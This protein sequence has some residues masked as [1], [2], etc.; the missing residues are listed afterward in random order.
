MAGTVVAGESNTVTWT[1]AIS[2]QECIE[3][4]LA[5]NLEIQVERINPRIA[6]WGVVREQGGFEPTLNGRINYQDNHT[7]LDPETARSLGFTNIVDQQLKFGAD[8][9]GKLPTGASYDLSALDTRYGGTLQPSN[10]LHIAS[11]VLTLDQPL[12]RNF[13]FG[14][15][16]ASIRVARKNRQIV[17]EQFRQRVI[18][19]VTAVIDAYYDLVR[20]I[21]DHKAQVEDLD[22]AQTLL[23]Q[24]RK[25]VDAGILPPIEVTQAEAGVAER[26]EGVIVTEQAIRDQENTVK[27]LISRDAL[28]LVDASLVPV[29]H[30][31]TEITAVDAKQSIRMA[32]ENRPDFLQAKHEL[33]RRGILLK[34]MRNQL[35]P[36]IDVQGSYGLNGRA[37][38]GFGDTA[39]NLSAGDNPQWS[40]GV[41]V[42]IPLG[43][44][45]ARADYFSARE[46]E[47]RA[48]L[49]LKRLEQ[50]IVV[51]VGNLTGQVR[52]N[53]KRMDATR[54]ARRLAEE[55]LHAEEE[56]LHAGDSTSL[57]V[58]QA[59]SQLAGTRSAEIRAT[60]DYN[61]SLVELTR[62]EGT[63]L[64]KHHIDLAEDSAP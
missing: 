4:A 18:D 55:A 17:G 26:E 42:S 60:T 39:D 19:T 9:G 1:K 56:K 45:R 24:N 64:Q 51:Q 49:D 12:L 46:E 35:L 3:Q 6:D 41:V 20:A 40:V 23:D 47:Q 16:T 63:T 44:R 7:P 59:Q 53:L 21:E 32:L 2:L 28:A 27:R 58:L 33:E 43:N 8:L 15:N 14:P 10:Y 54:A 22:R 37:I 38:T 5:Q 34:Y 52:T 62:A 29:D 30:P 25:E 57:L 31:V 48:V 61:K 36:Q 13:G 11:T 50:D